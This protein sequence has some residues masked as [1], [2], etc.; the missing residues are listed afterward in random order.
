MRA[1]KRVHHVAGRRRGPY[2]VSGGR[3]TLYDAQGNESLIFA[4]ATTVGPRLASS[5]RP[6]SE[7]AR[8]GTL[9][10]WC[11]PNLLSLAPRASASPT[12]GTSCGRHSP[13]CTRRFHSC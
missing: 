8:C 5:P 11:L 10:T 1:E 12:C 7:L 3:L 2:R 6:F 13:S 9:G 4:A